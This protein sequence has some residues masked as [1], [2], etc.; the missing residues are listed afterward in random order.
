[1]LATPLAPATPLPRCC[2]LNL[3]ASA[4]SD[5]ISVRTQ[6]SLGEE[7]P[8][9]AA[10]NIVVVQRIQAQQKTSNRNQAQQNNMTRISPSK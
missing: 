3:A 6:R 2:P 1:M 9:H 4:P 8:K 5:G 7:K 10:P